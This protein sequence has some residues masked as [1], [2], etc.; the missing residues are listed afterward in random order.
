MASTSIEKA[1]DQLHAHDH[2]CLIYETREQQMAA[3]LPYIRSGLRNN[4]LCVYI[5]DGNTAD[6]VLGEL[7]S[8][9][10]DIEDALA[11]GRL[12]VTASVGSYVVDGT[13]DVDRMMTFLD[14]ATQGALAAGFAAIRIT[15]EMSWVLAGNPGTDRL[16]EYEARINEFT[17]DHAVSGV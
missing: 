16:F 14:Q 1:I 12:Q 17:V 13:F 11:E 15:G 10:V 6:A 8:A 9:G 4:E 3:A 2:A 7:R 5:A